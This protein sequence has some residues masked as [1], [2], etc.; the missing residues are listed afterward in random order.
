MCLG[1]GEF[2]E[3]DEDCLLE[4]HRGQL[5]QE[6][7]EAEEEVEEDF[8][9]SLFFFTFFLNSIF[10]IYLFLFATSSTHVSFIFA[11]SSPNSQIDGL[12]NT[13]IKLQ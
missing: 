12:T 7:E 10:N 2:R 5:G 3:G 8:F 1:V 13:C 9:F 6:V 4:L 11:M